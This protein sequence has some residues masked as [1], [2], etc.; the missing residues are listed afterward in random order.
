M[1]EVLYAVAGARFPSIA[2]KNVSE[3]VWCKGRNLGCDPCDTLP[4]GIPPPIPTQE[5]KE[6]STYSRQGRPYDMWICLTLSFAPL[7]NIMTNSGY[8]IHILPRN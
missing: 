1:E 5:R 8:N 7:D 6:S 4:G 3:V 2:K